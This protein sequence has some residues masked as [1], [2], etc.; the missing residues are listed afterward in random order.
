[1]AKLTHKLC[2]F[3]YYVKRM[4]EKRI[5]FRLFVSPLVPSLWTSYI[6]SVLETASGVVAKCHQNCLGYQNFLFGG[7][8]FDIRTLISAVFKSYWAM[9][10]RP[11]VQK[12]RNVWIIN[13]ECFMKH[14]FAWT[15]N[16]LGVWEIKIQIWATALIWRVSGTVQRITQIYFVCAYF[17]L[18]N[19]DYNN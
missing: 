6:Q 12:M 9:F 7:P 15:I 10:L 11:E 14:C 2:L 1:M 18:F 19:I 13:I 17:M 5:L 4:F 8:N 3:S 16:Y